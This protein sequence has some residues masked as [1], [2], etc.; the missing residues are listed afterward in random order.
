MKKSTILIAVFAVVALVNMAKAMEATF[1]FDGSGRPASFAAML[2]E[3]PVAAAPVAGPLSEDKSKRENV[4]LKLEK[5]KQLSLA[6][7]IATKNL[8]SSEVVMAIA[9][10]K[11]DIL[12][13]NTA[14]YFVSSDGGSYITVLK[15]SDKRLIG[16]LLKV[17][18]TTLQNK[19]VW[20]QVVEHILWVLVEGVWTRVVEQYEECHSGSNPSTNNP[21]NSGSGGPITWPVRSTKF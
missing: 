3:I 9:D 11:I 21:G 17:N 16:L 13:N 15:S 4:F 10:P 6:E 5:G 8:F 19:N 20:C 14:V 12:Y 18:V 1:S 2:E 7:G